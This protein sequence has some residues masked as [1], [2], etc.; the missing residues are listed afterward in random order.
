M[1]MTPA[2]AIVAC[3]LNAAA[4]IASDAELGSIEP[5][6]LAD[7]AFFD[8]V[9]YRQLPFFLG[10]NLCSRTIR[11]GKIIYQAPPVRPTL[12]GSTR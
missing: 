5:G 2:E 1:R 10:F 8:V 7:I 6:K 11:R 3:T 4:A 9:D 12:S